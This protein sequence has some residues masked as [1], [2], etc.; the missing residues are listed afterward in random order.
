MVRL[1]G[2][3]ESIYAKLAE[4][5]CAAPALGPALLSRLIKSVC[6]RI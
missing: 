3:D 5:I 4:Q 1:A 6:P 2:D